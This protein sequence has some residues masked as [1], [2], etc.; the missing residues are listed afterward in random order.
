[1]RILYP[2]L[3]AVADVNEALTGAEAVALLTEW[4]EYKQMDPSQTIK[5]VSDPYIFDGRNVL[6]PEQWRSAG[7]S[8]RGF[9]R[10]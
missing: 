7:W 6:N 3:E 8:Y 9:G 2:E 4:P 10:P 5:Q 1:V